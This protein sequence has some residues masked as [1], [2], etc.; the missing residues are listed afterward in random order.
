MRLSCSLLIAGCTSMSIYMSQIGK[1][2][3][4]LCSENLENRTQWHDYSGGKGLTTEIDI[5]HCGFSETPSIVTSLGE[6]SHH[7]RF[8]GIGAV[9]EPTKSSFKVYLDTRTVQEEY[10]PASKTSNV[11]LHVMYQAHGRIC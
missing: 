2:C 7:W 1:G 8:V 9:Y 11:N 10:L 4:R 5:S 3:I 6:N